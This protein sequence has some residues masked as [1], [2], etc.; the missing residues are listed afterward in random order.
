VEGVLTASVSLDG[1]RYAASPGARLAYFNAVLYRLRKL[2]GIRLAS[3]TDFL[4]LYSKAFLGGPFSLDG[5]KAAPGV[6]TD[7]LPVM[8]E[9]FATTGGHLL[10]GR[11]FTDAEVQSDAN[12]AI[13]NDA[14]ANMF[15]GTTNAVGHLETTP[16]N[17]NRKIIGVVKSVDFMERYLQNFGDLNPPETFIPAHSPGRFDATFVAR[18]QG[19]P[20]D[21]VGM[22]R[23]AV[24]SDD[25]GVPVF[26]VKSMGQRFEEAFARPKFY[27]NALFFFSGFGLM[28]AVIGIYAVVSYAATQR[29]H[30]M[31][32]RL[33]MGTTP[34]HLR[35]VLLR[36]GLVSVLI[37]TL[38]GAFGASLVG[39]LL[40]G[41]V[42]GAS[43]ID[44]ATYI[45]AVPSLCLVA[46]LSIWIASRR[47]SRLDIAGV[48]RAE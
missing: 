34:A 41:L 38:A 19:R 46:A 32:V 7:L 13:V 35:G 29:M 37:G 27:R 39:R 22:I 2:P 26:A 47:I 10:Y 30:E 28:L 43:T 3:A 40:E 18:T 1:T 6:G 45:F 14:F 48:L 31:G 33:A 24:Q 9:Y 23:Q 5:R 16:D 8:S 36:Q 44:P 42:E 25:P 4:P 20:E 11:E 21:H 15:L 17:R 12:V